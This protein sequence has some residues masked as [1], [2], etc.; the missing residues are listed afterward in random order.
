MLTGH[1][2]DGGLL[3][4]LQIAARWGHATLRV[5]TADRTLALR[6]VDGRL[7]DA[8]DEGR[9]IDGPL[10]ARLSRLGVIDEA[11]LSRALGQSAAT[12]SPLPEVLRTEHGVPEVWIRA[13]RA[14]DRTDAWLSVFAETRG[15]F[16]LRPDGAPAEPADDAPTVDGVILAG[17]EL[18]RAWPAVERWVPRWD[19]VVERRVAAR[20]AAGEAPRDV[21]DLEADLWGRARPGARAGALADAAPGPRT[22]ARWAL[23]RLVSRGALTWAPAVAN[24]RRASSVALLSFGEVDERTTEAAD[25]HARRADDE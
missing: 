15:T 20:A 22:Y 16:V 11:G 19:L 8:R 4:A 24:C 6:L 2:A 14:W 9:P 7:A 23:A 5:E 1:L 17:L 12:G 13:V 10:A 21:A 25:Q 18:A 3:D